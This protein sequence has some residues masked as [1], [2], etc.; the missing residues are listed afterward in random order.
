LTAGVPVVALAGKSFAARHS[1]S[2]LTWSGA[3]ELVA[4][5]V[6]QYIDLAVGLA[7][8]PE[9]L[10]GYRTSLPAGLRRPGGPADI[11]GFVKD[12]TEV[13][14][15]L[16]AEAKDIR[17]AKPLVTLVR[18]PPVV[19]HSVREAVSRAFDLCDEAIS[20]AW[21]M[22]RD[23]LEVIL[24]TLLETKPSTLIEFGSGVSTIATLLLAEPLGLRRLVTYEHE[25]GWADRV[26][27]W[28]RMIGGEN[29]LTVRHR[30]LV[31]SEWRGL[32]GDFY[33]VDAGDLVMSFD[34]VV[35]DGPPSVNVAGEHRRAMAGMVIERCLR[36]GGVAFLEDANRAVETTA[37]RAW[38]EA[39]L[40]SEAALIEVG[41]GLF[42]GERG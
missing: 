7:K 37:Y 32:A 14:D 28:A 24:A 42:K 29:L 27:A 13:L 9:R 34:C 36:P 35:V 12:F 17:K 10:V 5:S 18:T 30:S 16:G 33:D 39:G 26:S 19:P 40:F 1:A 21:A 25:A 6:S 8:A 20:P 4:A 38:T 41:R 31:R 23:T 2:H 11:E 3:P 15:R 22:P